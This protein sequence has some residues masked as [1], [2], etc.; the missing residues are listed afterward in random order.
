[1][2]KVMLEAHKNLLRWLPRSIEEL[3][4]KAKKSYRH[5]QKLCTQEQVDFAEA[6]RAMSDKKF[7]AYFYS[8]SSES[9]SLIET[10]G[11][12]LDNNHALD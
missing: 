6:L 11:G 2:D 10:K 5:R 8:L 12:I 3:E 4:R 9:Q 1:M 7:E